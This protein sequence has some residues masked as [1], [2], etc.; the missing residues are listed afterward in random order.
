MN[1]RMTM[2]VDV[3][4]YVDS[5][6]NAH[7]CTGVLYRFPT[8]ADLVPLHRLRASVQRPNLSVKSPFLWQ[9]TWAPAHQIQGR[10][11]SYDTT[12]QEP[13]EAP[14]ELPAPGPGWRGPS[15][16]MEGFDS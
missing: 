11:T 10:V 7:L 13:P 15:P 2:D 14:A 9:V 16:A 6:K 3:D 1:G 5:L 4:G 12:C 8:V